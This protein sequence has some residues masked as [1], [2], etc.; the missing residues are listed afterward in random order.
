MIVKYGMGK[1]IVYPHHNK[2][3]KIFIDKDIIDECS[4][5]LLKSQ[6]LTPENIGNNYEKI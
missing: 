6:L 4:K 2:N 5:A 3:F 1:N